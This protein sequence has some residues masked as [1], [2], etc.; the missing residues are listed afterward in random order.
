VK[1]PLPV[2]PD[3]P[4]RVQVP[5]MFPVV[6][7]RFPWRVTTL[8]WPW[9]NS[10]EMVIAKAPVTIPFELPVALKVAVSLVWEIKHM[11]GKLKFE[12]LTAI[13]LPRARFVVNPEASVPS[14]FLS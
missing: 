14:G 13:P 8:F 12:T 10:V 3:C 5:E 1:D 4:V 7:S 6:A 11:D 2:H 9:G